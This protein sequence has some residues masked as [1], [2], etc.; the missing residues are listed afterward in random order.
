MVNGVLPSI[1]NTYRVPSVEV[2]PLGAQP[3]LNT[4]YSIDVVP[5]QLAENQQLESVRELFRYI[6]SVQGENIRP[7][8]RGLQAGVVQNTRIDG[9]N[10]AATTDYAIEQF[11]RIEV[12]N[13]LAG[14]LYGPASPAGTFNYV[15]KRPTAGPLNAF[16][17]AYASQDSLIEHA[18]IS[19]RF[20]PDGMFGVRVN[21]LNQAGQNYVDESGLKRRLASLAFDAQLRP[22]TQVQFDF[23]TYRYIDTGFPGT[24]SLAQGVPFP[25]SVPDVTKRGYGLPWAGDDNETHIFAGRLF[26]DLGPNWKLSGGLLYMTNDRA[27]T[28]PT[29]TITNTS[30]AYTATTVNTTYALDRVLSNTAALNGKVAFSSLVN[31]LFLGTTG[32]TWQRYTPFQTGAITLGKATLAD[33]V[34]F[35]EPVLPNFQYRY[36]V[37][38]T[39]QQSLNFGDTLEIGPQVSILAAASQSWISSV[40][41]NKT[42]AITSQYSAD[43][44]SPTASLIYKPLANTTAYLTYANSLQQGDTAP[45]GTTNAGEALAPYRSKEWE[46]GYKLALAKLNL[47]L[48]LY[49]IERPYAFTQPDKT[50][51]L[52]GDQ[53]NRG[54]EFTLNGRVT[55]ALNVYGGVSLLDPKLLD[56]S[57]A[58]TSDK[59]ILGLSKV[60]LDV[61]LEYRLPVLRALTLTSNIQYASRRA[62]NYTNTDFVDGYAVLDLGARYQ[63]HLAHRPVALRLDVANVND[64]RYWANIA[65]VGQNGYT[66][67]DS[68]TGT[69]GAPRTVRASIEVG[70]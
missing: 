16:T 28:A 7:Q 22:N 5:V 26:Q 36:R 30:G 53:R 67:T 68:G 2:G 57:S 47:A 14:A 52:G 50:F 40:N 51:A 49:Q 23:S 32:F 4:P 31:N 48:A 66:G 25:N 62:G 41:I 15:F 38:A 19:H 64:E 33:P 54:L 70:F 13:G 21:L 59:L 9:L 42:G 65:P 3:L 60:T 6:P 46:L 37:Q 10:I 29:D 55:P 18:D 63:L 44:V 58:A 43:G 45:A 20:G 34:V 61:L 17:L 24:F 11:D 1:D 8:S 56:T 12:L 39:D 27:S 69:L 35:S